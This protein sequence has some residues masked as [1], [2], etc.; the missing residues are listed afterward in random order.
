MHTE[1]NDHVSTEIG[2]TWVRTLSHYLLF[3]K[4]RTTV[5]ASADPYDS[6]RIV[7]FGW[8]T[9]D[10]TVLQMLHDVLVAKVNEH[11]FG[12]FKEAAQLLCSQDTV[13]QTAGKVKLLRLLSAQVGAHVTLVV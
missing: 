1:L 11:G 7:S 2:D 13:K 6:N 9:T 12:P 4:P 8:D 3:K 5:F 10:A